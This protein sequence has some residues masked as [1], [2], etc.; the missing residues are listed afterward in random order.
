MGFCVRAV[1]HHSF[2]GFN[3]CAAV[4][5]IYH[6]EWNG[7]FNIFDNISVEGSWYTSLVSGN[8]TQTSV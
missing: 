1:Q 5:L 6:P 7:A 4:R 3:D 8:E 2:N